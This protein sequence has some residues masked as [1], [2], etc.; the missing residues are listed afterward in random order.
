MDKMVNMNNIFRIFFGATFFAMIL[1]S[2]ASDPSATA[3]ASTTQNDD[4]E[5]KFTKTI[6]PAEFMAKYN[7]MPGATMVDVR[8]RKEYVDGRIVPEAV[9]IDY[10]GDQFLEEILSQ[11]KNTPIFVYCFSGGRSSKAAYKMRQ[12]GFDRIYECKGGYQAWE[13]ENKK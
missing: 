8:T 11:D 4:S 12:L 5:A 10:H 9:N 7:A 3:S 1:L 2:C 13:K 6:P